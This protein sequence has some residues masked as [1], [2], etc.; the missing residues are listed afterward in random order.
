DTNITSS[1][2]LSN[3]TLHIIP[4]PGPANAATDEVSDS[5]PP[6]QNSEVHNKSSREHQQK[7]IRM[8]VRRLL[9]DEM[10]ALAGGTMV[11]GTLLVTT[12]VIM[13][14][15]DVSDPL[16]VS[17]VDPQKF[18]M[19]VYM[20]EIK[21][22]THE[23]PVQ[24]KLAA[25]EGHSSPAHS[26]QPLHFTDKSPSN[27]VSHPHAV[28]GQSVL[29][30]SQS[31]TRGADSN[32][33]V[34]KLSISDN[35]EQ[36]QLT[37]KKA[38]GCHAVKTNLDDSDKSDSLGNSSDEEEKSPSVRSRSATLDN[39]TT[40]EEKESKREKSPLHITKSLSGRS[41]PWSSKAQSMVDK[42]A[43]QVSSLSW[44][45][46]SVDQ[47]D[48][49]PKSRDSSPHSSYFRAPAPISRLFNYTSNL[50]QGQPAA[51][52]DSPPSTAD[53][54]EKSSPSPRL[55]L[56][57]HF[58]K[59]DMSRALGPDP[60]GFLLRSDSRHF[61]DPP[62]YL[63]I[64][65]GV[66]KN[67]QIMQTRAFD[68]WNTG[69][70]LNEYWFVVPRV[71]GDKLYNFLM[72]WQPDAYG[73]EEETQPRGQFFYDADEV[74]SL[75]IPFIKVTA[76]DESREDLLLS[77]DH[78]RESEKTW[79]ILSKEE[80]YGAEKQQ[81][82]Y[83]QDTIDDS[84]PPELIGPTVIIN[85]EYMRAILRSLPPSMTVGYDWKLVYGTHKHGYSLQNMYMKTEELEEDEPVLL[86]I[87]DTHGAVFGAYLSNTIRQSETFY[88][89]GA[90]FLFTFL[91]EFKKFPWRR[92]N[93]YFMHGTKDFFAV[94]AGEGVFGLWLD[95]DLNKGRSYPC[96]TFMNDVLA[97]EEDFSILQLE[98]WKF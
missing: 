2:S 75:G 34:A 27:I 56:K 71:M 64:R 61:V 86:F 89:T 38:D 72:T 1:P 42:L 5:L 40:S 67:V 21:S 47:K 18:N 85:P 48:K 53:I 80:I 33:E 57:S 19:V 51:D 25:E 9:E 63:Q 62:L 84:S 60:R 77:D 58:T 91:P 31:S 28:H 90:T 20:E 49:S 4:P 73:D 23:S 43:L 13:F 44:G 46:T 54:K 11:K 76:G 22:K 17:S 74:N 7:F 94:G 97:T 81:S 59:E 29:E 16:V 65:R 14:D 35:A 93:N 36:P 66:R 70:V 12:N 79:E 37:E 92:N 30:L 78:F 45:D 95:S 32:E 3:H 98:V 82:L 41:S 52:K 68:H 24:H 96:T 39:D 83:R 8:P 87:T 55:Q 26:F 50:F 15:S 69:P 6:E 10:D 88:G